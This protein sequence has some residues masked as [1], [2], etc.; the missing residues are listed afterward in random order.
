MNKEDTQKEE[1]SIINFA[2]KK[3]DIDF[4]IIQDYD[5]SDSENENVAIIIESKKNSNEVI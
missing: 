2:N 5:L 4:N 3:F 1:K